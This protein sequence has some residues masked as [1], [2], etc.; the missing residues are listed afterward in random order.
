MQNIDKNTHKTRT[1]QMENNI[2]QMKINEIECEHN[3]E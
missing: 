2:T 3:T 1:L